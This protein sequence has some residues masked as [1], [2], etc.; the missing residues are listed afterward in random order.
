MRPRSVR[1]V[2]KRPGEDVQ[3]LELVIPGDPGG[4]LS[5]LQAVVGGYIE[6]LGRLPRPHGGVICYVNE[7]GRM[8]ELPYNFTCG[9][10]RLTGTHVVGPALFVG[11]TDGDLRDLTDAEAEAVR[12]LRQEYQVD[13]PEGESGTWRI[14]REVQTAAKA[15]HESI[16]GA[17]RGE[18]RHVPEGTYTV[19][20]R[21]RTVVMSDTPDEIRD[22][23]G[24]VQR[25]TGRVLIAGLG[26]GMVLQAV[27][28]K[29][30]VSHVTVIEQSED[31]IRLVADH[32]RAKPFGT[33]IEIVHHDVMEWRPP[34]TAR[35]DSAWFDIWDDLCTD[36]LPEMAT[37]HRR[38]ARRVS[39]YYG[40]W[41]HGLLKYRREQE[42]RMGW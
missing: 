17:I 16:M 5:A 7:E 39:T 31:V 35:W 28:R 36:N 38:Y 32:Y 11:D 41:C 20:Y 9:F 6:L 33:K 42:R 8:H 19:L 10:G 1:T 24:F 27:A 23:L 15:E 18:S 29:D 30:D 25:A 13:V 12:N 4:E 40:S 22:H 26:L 21:G 37:L 3:E 2:V 14:K 34:R